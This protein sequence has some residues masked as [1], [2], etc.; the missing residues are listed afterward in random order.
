MPLLEW[1]F[2]CHC[3]A[4]SALVSHYN[5][6]VLFSVSSLLH[7]IT[8]LFSLTSCFLQK[9][10]YAFNISLLFSSNSIFFLFVHFIIPTSFYLFLLSVIFLPLLL[11]FSFLLSLPFFSF[12]LPSAGKRERNQVRSFL[13]HLYFII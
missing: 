12:W 1:E 9:S 7:F 11:L 8:R 10:S 3:T 4:E 6:G 2:C 5:L 13:C